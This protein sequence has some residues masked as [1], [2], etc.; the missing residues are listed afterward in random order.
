M[1]IECDGCPPSILQQHWWGLSAPSAS[2]AGGRQGNKQPVFPTLFSGT[3]FSLVLFLA[4]LPE[5][6]EETIKHKM[7]KPPQKKLSL[8]ATLVDELGGKGKVIKL[9]QNR[10]IANRG[11]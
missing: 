7:G 2:L 3:S 8:P 4:A 10:T 11:R 1:M 5:N 6:I 9:R